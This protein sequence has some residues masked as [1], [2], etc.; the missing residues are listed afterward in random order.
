[1]FEHC[2]GVIDGLAIRIRCPRFAAN[3]HSYFNRKGYYSMN[4]QAVCDANLVIRCYS[5]R[6]VGATHDSLAYNVMDLSKVSPR[7]GKASGR[8]LDCWR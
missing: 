1:V 3:P 5:L 6:T 7:S 8:L 2:V 4:L